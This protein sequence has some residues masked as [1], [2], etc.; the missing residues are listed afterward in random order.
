MCTS[1]C[2]CALA[3]ALAFACIYG[4]CWFS[5]TACLSLVCVAQAQLAATYFRHINL[6]QCIEVV[7]HVVVANVV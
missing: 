6:I 5:G 2:V 1:I 3:F 7:V 4:I